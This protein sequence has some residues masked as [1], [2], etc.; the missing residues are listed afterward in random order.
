[1]RP[2]SAAVRV[3]ALRKLRTRRIYSPSPSSYTLRL[4][5]STRVQTKHTHQRLLFQGRRRLRKQCAL[6]S[7]GWAPGS[8]LH[9]LS[10]SMNSSLLC[11]L[12]SALCSLARSS[13]AQPQLSVRPPSTA[14]IPQQHCCR[15]AARPAQPAASA[16][17]SA[18]SRI[19]RDISSPLSPAHSSLRSAIDLSEDDRRRSPLSDRSLRRRRRACR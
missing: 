19:E 17:C 15:P 4:S 16:T 3:V 10:H 6:R 18:E 11:S 14:T 2:G 9:S 5:H 8:S 1:M 13:S 12:L 7:A